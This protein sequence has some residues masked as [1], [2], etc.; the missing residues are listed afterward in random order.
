MLLV[1]RRGT[2]QVTLIFRGGGGVQTSH[3]I[4]VSHFQDQI[5]FSQV[6]VGQNRFLYAIQIRNQLCSGAANRLQ[7]YCTE[8]VCLCV[9]PSEMTLKWHANSKYIVIQLDMRVD[10]P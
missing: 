9:C 6:I 10:T 5:F 7:N 4:F 2:T 8:V 3:N 1:E